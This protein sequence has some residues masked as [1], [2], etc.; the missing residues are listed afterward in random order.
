MDKQSRTPKLEICC[1]DLA[2]AKAAEKGGADRIEL[3]I[4]LEIGG[5]SPDFNLLATVKEALTI[6]VYAL[7]RPR[8]GHF[9]YSAEEKKWIRS[10]IEENILGGADGIVF[11]ALLEN[12]EIDLPFIQEVIQDLEGIP[13]TFHRA[14]DLVRDPEKSLSSLI[15]LDI[16]TVLSSGQGNT[17]IEGMH[18]LKEWNKTYGKDICIMPGSGVHSANIEQLHQA[19][20]ADYY[21]ASAKKT[22]G[23][24]ANP[25]P[26]LQK[27][28]SFQSYFQTDILE[29]E[30]LKAL[31]A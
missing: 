25:S 11:G 24:I 27:N 22:M 6:P 26:F 28:P 1:C 10:Q 14:F 23:A 20:Q 30:R 17:A 13:F 29:V 18:N 21:H 8:P 3:C 15:E 9:V 16:L 12:F 7:I 5:L 2:S 31:L 19:V 4:G